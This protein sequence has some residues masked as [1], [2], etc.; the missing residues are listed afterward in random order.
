MATPTMPRWTLM[1]CGICARR[2]IGVMISSRAIM[3]MTATVRCPSSEPRPSPT[4]R[5][6]VASSSS[7]S[8]VLTIRFSG[9][10]RKFDA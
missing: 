10:L 5:P 9:G 6:I 8:P 2:A 7:H 4:T 3:R 1:K